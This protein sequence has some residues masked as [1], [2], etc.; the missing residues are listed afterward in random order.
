M[1]QFHTLC[2]S[3]QKIEVRFLTLFLTIIEQIKNGVHF[4]FILLSTQ[5]IFLSFFGKFI[6]DFT[7]NFYSRLPLEEKHCTDIRT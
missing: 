1:E 2:I 6:E 4:L 5:L 7:D 3:R